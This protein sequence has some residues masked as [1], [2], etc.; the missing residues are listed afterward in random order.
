MQFVQ[1]V[2]WTYDRTAWQGSGG[3]LS[4]ESLKS[5][6]LII[7]STEPSPIRGGYDYST[8]APASTERLLDWYAV[9]SKPQEM[10]RRG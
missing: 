4:G 6:S 9:P 7:P 5:F 10:M 2:R 1:C 3:D 8:D